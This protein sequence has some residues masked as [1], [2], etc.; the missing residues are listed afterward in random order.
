MSVRFLWSKVVPSAVPGRAFDVFWQAESDTVD[1]LFFNVYVGEGPS[2]PWVPHFSDH[3][4]VSQAIG[5]G[6]DIGLMSRNLYA[7]IFV[8]TSGLSVLEFEDQLVAFEDQHLATGGDG[9]DPTGAI[10]RQ[11][12]MDP[13]HQFTE[14]DWIHW[15]EHRRKEALALRHSTGFPGFFLRRRRIAP[16][17]PAC[18]DEILGTKL[19]IN[20]QCRTCFGTGLAGGFHKPYRILADWK[21]RPQ[22]GSPSRSNATAT[23]EHHDQFAIK[24]LAHPYEALEGDMWVDAGTGHRYHVG[25][26][27]PVL[28][29][30]WPVAQIMGL[31]IIP[32]TD[33]AYKLK[34]PGLYDNA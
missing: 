18:S 6:H 26:I 24:T 23:R 27:E 21:G 17:C 14:R 4:P 8:F 11:K 1:P 31:R 15:R 2:G 25:A 12:I 9:P 34:I 16:P 22:P 28:F 7:S 13:G 33:I 5:V 19:N 32:K 20:S 30:V 3:L 29:K 10:A